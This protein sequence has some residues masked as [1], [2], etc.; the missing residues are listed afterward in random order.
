MDY[1][2]AAAFLNLHILVSKAKVPLECFSEATTCLQRAET[3]ASIAQDYL[4][5]LDDAIEVLEMSLLTHR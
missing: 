1:H 5:A 2:H 4:A 3:L